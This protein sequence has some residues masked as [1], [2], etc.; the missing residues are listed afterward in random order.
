[1]GKNKTLRDHASELAETLAPHVELARDK[2]A[3]LLAD[4][5]DKAA[6]VLAEARVKAAPVLTEVR[7]KAAPLL[8]DARDKAAP[9]LADARDKAA[10]Y[11]AD[12]RDR[13]TTEVL[14]VVTAALASVD[15]AT[16]DARAET[17]KRGKAVAAALK[18]EV[19]APKEK[20]R[21][22]LLLIL[23]GIGGA[24]FAGV[25]VMANRRATTNWQSSYTP[26]PATPSTTT[27]TSSPSG[28]GLV[29]G[30]EGGLHRAEASPDDTAASDP[31]EAVSDA[32][33]VPHPS[34]T[35]D[36]PVTEVDVDR[37]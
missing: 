26:P 21:G 6:P 36:N 18:G 5:R 16:E 30:S 27:G 37:E 17:L 20:H 13:F 29:A 12:A 1:M 14:P 32:T 23:L 3:P 9:V 10:P 15:A 19:E 22:R 31:A 25:R 28:E 34:S 8:A 33:D 4:A 7:D 2:A 11:V 24:V 35:P